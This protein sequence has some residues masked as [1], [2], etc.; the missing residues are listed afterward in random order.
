[1]STVTFK[2]DLSD[3]AGTILGRGELVRHS[4]PD[5]GNV[6]GLGVKFISFAD[7]GAQLL[8]TYLESLNREPDPTSATRSAPETPSKPKRIRKLDPDITLEFE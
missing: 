4:T 7:D 6:D 2:I 3:P 1:M 8:Q 5:Q